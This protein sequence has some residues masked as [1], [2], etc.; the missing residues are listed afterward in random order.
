LPKFDQVSISTSFLWL[1]HKGLM[2]TG[3][4]GSIVYAYI[5]TDI[6]QPDNSLNI[7]ASSTTFN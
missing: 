4:I 3:N 7:T 5:L 6:L 1:Y 2:F